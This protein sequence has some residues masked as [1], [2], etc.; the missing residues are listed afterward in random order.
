MTVERRSLRPEDVAIS[1]SNC[2]ICHSDVHFAHDDWGMNQ[3]PM[4]PGHM[5]SLA[6]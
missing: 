3:Y 5:A 2:G 4:V 1:I 6:E